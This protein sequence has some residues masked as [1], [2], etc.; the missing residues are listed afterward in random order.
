ME[1][2]KCLRFLD[3]P[4]ISISTRW[5]NK[6]RDRWIDRSINILINRLIN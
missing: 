5:T 2:G 6:S 1:N 4:S 3:F